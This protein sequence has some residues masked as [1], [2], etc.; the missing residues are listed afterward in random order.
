VQPLGPVRFS[1][2]FLAVDRHARSGMAPQPGA[3]GRA[4]QQEPDEGGDPAC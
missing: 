1:I 3:D 2:E 4:Q